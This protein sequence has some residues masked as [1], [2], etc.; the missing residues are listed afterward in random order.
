MT[1]RTLM[2][3]L[4]LPAATGALAADPKPGTGAR[5]WPSGDERGMANAI[6]PAT[7]SRCVQMTIRNRSTRHG[8]PGA[9]CAPPGAFSG[10]SCQCSRLSGADQ[11]KHRIL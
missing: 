5:P 10:R 4:M 1:T 8:W 2:L 9:D 3:T 6:G 11:P 7:W